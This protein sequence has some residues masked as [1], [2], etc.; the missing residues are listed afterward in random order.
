MREIEATR[1]WIRRIVIGLNLCPFAKK[2]F[3][4]E[5]IRYVVT[6]TSDDAELMVELAGE[7]ELLKRKPIGE[8]ETT[9]LIH[10][11]ALEDFLDY[12]EFLESADRLIKHLGL[13]GVIQLAS[14]HPEYRFADTKPE[15]I[16]NYTN[17]S[18]FPMLHLLREESVTRV[19]ANEDELLE[20]PKRNIQTLRT[21]GKEKLLEL[22]NAG[23]S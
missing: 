14:F 10:P 3:D 16:E 21:L 18:P 9:L 11:N 12:N 2:V 7:L 1:D 4:E 23:G 15:D 19:A 17:R 8:I 20:I 22:I 6:Q 13:E 5:K